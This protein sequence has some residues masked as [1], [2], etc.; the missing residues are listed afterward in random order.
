MMT[1]KRLSS[2]SSRDGKPLVCNGTNWDVIEA[3][4]GPE[5]DDWIGKCI[6]LWRDP[7]VKFKGKR[8]GGIRVREIVPS[9]GADEKDIP[10]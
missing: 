4:Y 9:D 3:L 7:S 10:F 1:R 5:S 6:T 2:F 8:T